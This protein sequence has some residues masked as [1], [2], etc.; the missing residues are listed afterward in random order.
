MPTTKAMKI[1]VP[2]AKLIESAEAVRSRIIE[3][4]ESA[5]ANYEDAK[6]KYRSLVIDALRVALAE[7]TQEGDLPE[8]YSYGSCL[9]VP[10]DHDEPSEP[11]HTPNTTQVDRDLALLRATSDSELLISTDDMFAGYLS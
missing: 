9:L 11:R 2:V 7:A 8:Y 4:H 10:F 6:G 1:K 3:Q 5:V